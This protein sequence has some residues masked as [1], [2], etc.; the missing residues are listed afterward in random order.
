MKKI[1]TFQGIVDFL[2]SHKSE[3]SDLYI[4]RD[5]TARQ[6][7]NHFGILHSQLFQK[8]CFL[9]F[10]PKGKGKGGARLG[11]GNRKEGREKR[12]VKASFFSIAIS[13][14]PEAMNILKSQTKYS[15]T[16]Y[17]EKAI[18]FYHKAQKTLLQHD[19]EG[20]VI[21]ES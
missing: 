7:A 16:A 8:G 20:E 9:V 2:E 10:G 11:S 6:I 12:K 14:S 21:V 3:A 5:Y 4:K 17:I 18:F 1:L 19:V 13:I 15:H